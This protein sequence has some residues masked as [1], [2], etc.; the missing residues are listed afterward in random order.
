MKKKINACDKP[1]IDTNHSEKN[2]VIKLSSLGFE[3][4]R[5]EFMEH[6]NKDFVMEKSGK[7]DENNHVEQDTIKIFF[8]TKQN[9][10]RKQMITISM[11]RTTCAVMVNGYSLKMFQEV[12][13]P[14]I[15]G[16]IL[17]QYNPAMEIQLK[18]ELIRWQSG[19]KGEE[20]YEMQP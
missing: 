3:L 6:Y 17:S 7:V 11:Y 15:E 9:K 19:D 2:T 18:N 12:D 4:A 5:N 1:S 10:K 13:F 8:K 16:H 20:H 14:I